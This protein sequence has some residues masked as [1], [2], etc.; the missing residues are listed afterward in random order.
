[1][2]HLPDI[3]RRALLLGLGGAVTLGRARLAL[4]AVPGD[5]RLVVVLLRGALDGLSAVQPYGDAGLRE[6]RGPLALPEPGREGGLLDLGGFFGLHPA[7]PRTHALFAAGEALAIHAVAGNWRSR[8][9]FDAQDFLESGQDRRLDAGWLNR[10][11]AAMPG[12]GGTPRGLAVGLDV[13]LLLRGTVRVTN[14]APPSPQPVQPDALAVLAGLHGRDPLLGPVFAEGLRGRGFSAAVL[15]GSAPPPGERNGFVALASAAGRLLAAQ[16]GPRVAALESQGWDTHAAQA[17][18]LQHLLGELD[19]GLGALREGLGG[20][21]S[22]TAVLVATEFGRT[23]RINGAGGTD[24]GTA[25]VALVL[26]GA[27]AGGRVLANWPSLRDLFENRDLAPTADLRALAKGLLAGHLRLPAAALAQAFPG[28][29]DA[30]PM[31][32]LLRG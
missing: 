7:M 6:L 15:A 23:V 31:A 28:S 17:G 21:W 32:G 16:D 26:G 2:R 14:Y 4:A 1:M 8:S 22:R 3:S 13:P 24:H 12:T 20:A 11:L 18:R 10:A 9:H 25:G 5:A 27:V 30:A 19:Q 29:G